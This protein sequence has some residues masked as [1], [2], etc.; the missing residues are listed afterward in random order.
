MT[1]NSPDILLQQLCAGACV[2]VIAEWAI[3]AI[4]S[5]SSSM[6]ERH[7]G[8]KPHVGPESLRDGPQ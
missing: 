6:G 4:R 7:N 1:A 8:V 5:G 3:V 2:G